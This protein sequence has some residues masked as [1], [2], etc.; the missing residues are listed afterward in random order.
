MWN[1]LDAGMET[2]AMVLTGGGLTSLQ[3]VESIINNRATVLVC[4]PSYAMRLAEVAAEND[5]NSRESAIRLILTAGE[6]GASIPGTRARIEQLWDARLYDSPGATEVGH[7]GYACLSQGVHLIESEIYFEVL[8]PTTMEPVSPG[9]TGEIV[10]TNFGRPDTPVI[11][12]RT[13]DIARPAEHPCGCGRTMLL[14][15]G[16][17]VGRSDDMFVVR[18]I[19]V[20][21]SAIE[22]VIRECAEVTEY[23]VEVFKEREMHSLKVKVEISRD[24]R[25]SPDDVLKRIRDGLHRRLYLQAHAEVVSANTLPRYEGKAKRIIWNQGGVPS[26]HGAST[27]S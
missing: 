19:N 2:G 27:G 20:F 14:L 13:H 21:P 18:G 6:P 10:V 4:T 11:R 17:I 7:F 24:C 12:Y 25:T 23:A 8:N 22:S 5:L 3:R 1:V 16:G 9:E 15:D 26:G